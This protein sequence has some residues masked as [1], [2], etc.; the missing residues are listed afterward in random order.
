MGDGNFRPET[1]GEDIS[2]SSVDTADVTNSEIGDDVDYLDPRWVA[3]TE[4]TFDHQT[5]TSI[6]GWTNTTSGSGAVSVNFSEINVKTGTADGSTAALR[7]R[8]PRNRT[9]HSFNNDMT[10]GFGF[11]LNS[12]DNLGYLTVG[13]LEGGEQGFGF[14]LDGDLK[15]VIHNGTSETETTLVSSFTSSQNT[16]LVANF[17][18]GQAVEFKR[19]GTV[20]G[21]LSSGLPSGVN[22]FGTGLQIYMENSAS[23]AGDQ[24]VTVGDT[25]F[26]EVP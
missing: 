26:V 11:D 4:I 24:R 7:R 25:S 6:D 14:K 16:H 8:Y 15:G 20:E 18:A 2:L 1:R 3:Q 22:R 19:N 23:N 17:T 13:R 9:T 12:Q 10:V 5:H 21:S